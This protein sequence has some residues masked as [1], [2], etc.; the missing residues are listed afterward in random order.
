MLAR[1]FQLSRVGVSRGAIAA[2]ALCCGA[3]SVTPRTMQAAEPATAPLATTVAATNEPRVAFK[4]TIV[5]LATL[6]KTDPNEHPMNPVLASARDALVKISA[7][8]DYSCVLVAR[9]R[10]DGELKPVAR[11][12]LKVRHEPFSIYVS[13]LEP[14]KAKGQECIYIAGRNNG[15][16]WAHT[17][18]IKHRLLGTLSLDPLG[19]IAMNGNRHPVTEAGIRRL[20]ERMIM[21]GEREINQKDCKITLLPELEISGQKCQGVQIT[22]DSR[23]PDFMYHKV[24]I[25]VD[26]VLQFPVRFESFDWP[27]TAGGEAPLLEEYTYTELKFNNGFTD[28]DFSIENPAYAFGR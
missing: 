10:V 9:E 28:A 25:Y 22:H 17:T 7:Y 8:D 24:R 11:M 19:S 2:L 12:P 14:A 13:Y 27:A 20:V 5:D 4:P 16:M 18:G 6:I 26:P 1:L 3:T 15:K 21:V 23:H